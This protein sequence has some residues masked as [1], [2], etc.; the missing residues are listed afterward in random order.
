MGKFA[1]N[2]AESLFSYLLDYIDD[3]KILCL[4]SMLA[5]DKPQLFEKFEHYVKILILTLDD[6][7]TILKLSKELVAKYPLKFTQKHIDD[8]NLTEF[9]NTESN[10]SV[11]KFCIITAGKFCVF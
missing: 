3:A 9:V 2:V 8:F 10:F 1:D 11:E 6:H 7:E 5:I 4:K